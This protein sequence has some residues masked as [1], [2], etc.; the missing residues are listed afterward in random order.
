MATQT[1]QAGDRI[2]ILVKTPTESFV[3]P[4]E[5]VR[6]TPTGMIKARY[7]DGSIRNVWDHPIRHAA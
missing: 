5:I 1:F 7:P 3:V 2:E 4:A 6:V